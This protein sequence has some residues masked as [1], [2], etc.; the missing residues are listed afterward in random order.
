MNASKLT[1]FIDI[2]YAGPLEFY[3]RYIIHGPS[4]P[5][6]ESMEF[7]TLVHAV[8]EK[9][10]KEKISDAD[11][12]EFFKSEVLKLDL[13][14]AEQSRML[15]HGEVAISA[16]LSAFRNIL[17][18][19]HQTAKAE[20]DFHPEHL[21]YNGI[22]ITG[23]IDHINIDEK[24]KTIEI[25]DF[26]TSNFH[27]EKWESHASLYKYTLQLLFYK[28]LLNLSPTYRNY[29]VTKAHI[30]F[31][32]P[33]SNDLALS[34]LNGSAELVHDKVYEFSDAA[35]QDFKE[36]LTAVYRHI[37]S[38]DFIDECSPLAILP[39]QANGIK[40]IREFC[41]LIKDSANF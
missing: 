15:A 13:T 34:E 14:E 16:S 21:T 20:L 2:A 3:Q 27:K 24:N 35:E 28:L 11:A 26:K 18:P 23:K 29:K 38:L 30:L 25:Y 31:V 4:A 41:Q 39:D 37:K 33:S 17:T 1:T 8:F 6:S 36:L 10:T 40:Q 19:E 12:L 32:A 9:V 5:S 7:G 22:P